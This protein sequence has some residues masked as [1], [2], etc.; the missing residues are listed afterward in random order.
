MEQLLRYQGP[1]VHVD[2]S[3]R[4]PKKDMKISTCQPLVPTTYIEHI[5]DTQ[6]MQEI[7][8]LK[9]KYRGDTDMI[10]IWKTAEKRLIAGETP[11]YTGGL[12]SMPDPNPARE[13]KILSLRRQIEDSWDKK[14]IIKAFG[15][16]KLP[17]TE[18]GEGLRSLRRDL[19]FVRLGG[20]LDELKSSKWW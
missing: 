15:Q 11:T 16:Y 20:P 18:E 5:P 13:K 10:E 14:T 6:L 19:A 12:K 17:Y 3:F 4:L 2:H 9:K 8:E 7:K 1:L